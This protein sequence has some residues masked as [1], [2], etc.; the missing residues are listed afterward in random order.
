MADFSGTTRLFNYANPYHNPKFK[1]IKKL[2]RKF[3]K[4]HKN[5]RVDVGEY[6]EE[7]SIELARIPQRLH[8]LMICI[9]WLDSDTYAPAKHIDGFYS[10]TYHS[11]NKDL[12]TATWHYITVDRYI[13]LL[14]IDCNLQDRYNP[15]GNAA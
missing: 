4:R 1:E 7:F 11:F 2:E 9:G 8:S 13:D 15:Q 10:D 5:D 12:A 6:L 14:L 3:K